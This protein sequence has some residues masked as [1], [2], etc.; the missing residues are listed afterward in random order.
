MSTQPDQP[1]FKDRSSLYD[2][3]VRNENLVREQQIA[4][5]N[6]GLIRERLA[7][8]ART[9]GVNQFVNCKELRETYFALCQDRFKGMIFPEDAQPISRNVPGLIS[10]TK[11]KS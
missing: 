8:C 11:E 7:H 1:S 2:F 6:M 10:P 3:N 4:I 5:E 9:E